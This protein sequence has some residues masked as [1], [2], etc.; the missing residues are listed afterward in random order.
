MVLL[1]SAARAF[2]ETSVRFRAPLLLLQLLKPQRDLGLALSFSSTRVLLEL[3]VS[4]D[5]WRVCLL[6]SLLVL[7]L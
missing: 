5:P 2:L 7:S 4:A 1:L 6:R 3:R